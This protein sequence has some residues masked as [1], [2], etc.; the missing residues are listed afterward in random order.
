M[1]DNRQFRIGTLFARFEASY[2]CRTAHYPERLVV[3]V[4]P[5]GEP[6]IAPS[7][8]GALAPQHDCFNRRM[9]NIAIDVLELMF[10]GPVHVNEAIGSRR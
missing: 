4:R 3:T 5:Q 1:P 9:P 6:T 10:A 8:R 7:L 2:V